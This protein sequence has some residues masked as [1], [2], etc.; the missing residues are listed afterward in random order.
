MKT[1]GGKMILKSARV[2]CSEW[3]TTGTKTGTTVKDL[4]CWF[5]SGDAM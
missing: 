4:R 5:T 2:N 1:G 3:S